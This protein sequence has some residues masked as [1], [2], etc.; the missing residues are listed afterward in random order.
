MNRNVIYYPYIRVPQNEWFT[1]VL[2][3]WDQVFSVVPMDYA[4]NPSTLGEYMDDLIQEDLVIPIVPGQYIHEIPNFTKA[5]LDYVDSPNYPVT[6]LI[7]NRRRLKTFDVAMEKLDNI[8]EE[9]IKRGLARKYYGCY[10]IEAYTANQF[11]AYLAAILGKTP[12]IQSKPITD[13]KQNL[14][15]FAPHTGGKLYQDIDE[16]RTI[17]LKDILPAPSGYINPIELA[18]FKKDNLK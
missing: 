14:V 7:N 5:F 16:T 2:L 11:M 12:D 6:Q 4:S 17:I 18:N 3:Y 8:G 10:R 9:L 1:R 13:T 15:S